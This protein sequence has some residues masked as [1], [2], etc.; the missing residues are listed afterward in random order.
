MKTIAITLTVLNETK[1]YF[2]TKNV[3]II[4]LETKVK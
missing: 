1:I 3:H 4:I 2:D